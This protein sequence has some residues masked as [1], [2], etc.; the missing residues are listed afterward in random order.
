[1]AACLSSMSASMSSNKDK[2]LEGCDSCRELEL[3]SGDVMI[4]SGDPHTQLAHGVYDTIANTGPA[5]LP[6]WAHGCRVSVQY[7]LFRE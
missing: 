4:F 3:R 6:P 1:M 2:H 5:E 7:R